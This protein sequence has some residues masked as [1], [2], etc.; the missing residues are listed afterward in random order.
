M[1]NKLMTPPPRKKKNGPHGKSQT[2][3]TT[4]TSRK[5][6]SGLKMTGLTTQLTLMIS[7]SMNLISIGISKNLKK[8][9]DSMNSVKRITTN[10]VMKRTVKIQTA[11]GLNHQTGMP[12]L[13][14]NGN[15][16]HMTTPNMT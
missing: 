8:T 3:E 13:M 7:I 12:Q 9:L 16:I 4:G 11:S 2:M 15:M 6:K 10:G 14:E 1:P 5:K